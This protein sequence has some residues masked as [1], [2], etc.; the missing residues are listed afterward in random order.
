MDEGKTP[1]RQ[2]RGSKLENQLK[3]TTVSSKK[4]L[5]LIDYLTKTAEWYQILFDCTNDAVFIHSRNTD[6]SAGKYIEVNDI[7]CKLLGYTREELHKM[8]PSDIAASGNKSDSLARRQKLTAE[9]RLV[10]ETELVKKNGSHIFVEIS[11]NLFDFQDKSIV[12]ATVRDITN[13]K[14]AEE[15]LRESEQWYRHLFESANDAI[16][17]YKRK[18][19]QEP[20]TYTDVNSIACKRLGYTKKELLKM[21]PLNIIAPERLNRHSELR[22]KLLAEKHIVTETIHITKDGRRIPVE[23]NSHLFDIKGQNFVL[24]ISRD[25]TERKQTEEKLS[26][27]YEEVEKRVELRTAELHKANN[28]LLEEI[29]ER[30]M[31]E[32][33][34]HE[35]EKNF[36]NSLDNS[37]LGMAISHEIEGFLYVNKALLDI[38]G[39]S[40]LEELNAVPFKKRYTEKSCEVLRNWINRRDRHEPVTDDLE[41]RIITKSGEIRDLHIFRRE[42]LWNGK[43]QSIVIYHDITERKM[44]SEQLRNSAMLWQSTFDAISDAIC[45]LDIDNR[46]LRCNKSMIDITGKP[47]EEIQ[48]KSCWKVVHGSETHVKDCPF[49]RMKHTLQKET[50]VIE[51]DSR[52]LEVVAF[53][54]FDESEKLMG[55]VHIISDI[56]ERKLAEKEIEN[57]NDQLLQKTKELENANIHLQDVD[58][59][60]SIFLASM[61]HELRTPLNSIIGFTGIL[62]QGLVGE[63]NEEQK[64]QLNIVQ[65]SSTHL[66]SLINDVLD[67]S[68]LEAGKI[69]LTLEEFSFDSLIK[70]VLDIF[71]P[72]INMKRLNL[73]NSYPK[74]I[75]LHSDQR[76]IKQVLIN[77]LSNAVK[78]TDK[79]SITVKAELKD[80]YLEIG[81]KD[82]GI[83]ISKENINRLF[84]PFQQVDIA[85]TKKHEGTGLGLYLSKKLANFMGGDITVKSEFGKGSEF[86]YTIKYQ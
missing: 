13:R 69:E 76:R 80:G 83:G 51:Q 61:S 42:I 25:I 85:L 84:Q 14:Q 6:G 58:R 74:G 1:S 78:F 81:V 56:T 73:A 47:E 31:V 75:K 43:S 9:K 46:I 60:K 37:P 41:V 32:K 7:A 65:G 86:V 77:L 28:A 57:K 27:A 38:W 34:L 22:K 40:S 44:A 45:L 21:S 12:I 2:G 82:T 70:E 3:L 64:R 11:S 53:P 20:G 33:A 68:K 67:L 52:Y 8:T 71:I 29:N 23:N 36:R 15:A 10:F 54:Q 50:T 59:L 24:V 17:V 55:G 30:K 39:Y 79:G 26:K 5:K 62:L 18:S 49:D 35:S 16:F 19:E 63:L 72:M 4:Q 66:L 48:G